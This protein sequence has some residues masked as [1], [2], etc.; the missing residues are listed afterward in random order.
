MSKYDTQA[1]IATQ[2]QNIL[3]NRIAELDCLA[4]SP[5]LTRDELKDLKSRYDELALIIDNLKL[6]T[7]I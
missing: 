6:R 2:L 1:M 5:T 4:E 7:D 3:S